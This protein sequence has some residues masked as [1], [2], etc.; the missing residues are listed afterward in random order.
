MLQRNLFSAFDR[1]HPMTF[2]EGRS[3]IGRERRVLNRSLIHQ[4]AE[5]VRID[6]KFR[7]RTLRLRKKRKHPFR[8]A[9]L[10]L[11]NPRVRRSQSEDAGGLLNTLALTAANPSDKG[12]EQIRHR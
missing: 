1:Q 2:I 6:K 3:Q 12:R 8:R 9:E 7:E 4:V 11:N 5:F 10:S